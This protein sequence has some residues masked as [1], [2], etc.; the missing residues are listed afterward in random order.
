MVAFSGGADST[1]LLLAAAAVAPGLGLGLHAAW[2]DHGIRPAEERARE[3]TFVEDLASRLGIPCHVEEA[4]VYPLESRAARR[5]TSLE[6]EAREFRYR[7]LRKAAGRSGCERIL[8]AHTRDDQ[9]ETL[10]ARILSGSGAAGLRGIPE[11][12]PPYLRPFLSLSKASL[13]RYLRDRGQEWREDSTNAGEDYLRNRIRLRL[14]PAVEREFPG[15]RKALSKLA[16]KSGFDEDCL[17]ARTEAEL[18][19]SRKE[20]RSSLDARTF[21][22]APPALRIRA[23]TAEA[24]RY[25]E[26]GRRVPYALVRAAA[27]PGVRPA[28]GG[29]LSRGMGIRIRQEGDRIVVSA[30][31]A[32]RLPGL[33]D[34]AGEG[35]PGPVTFPAGYSFHFERPGT[36]RIDTDASCTIYFRRGSTGPGEGTFEFPLT[37][38]SRLPGDRL[39]IP[40]GRKPLDEV[41]ADLKVPREWRDFLPV[42]EDRNGIMGV[43]GFPAGVRDRYR[44]GPGV[45][46]PNGLRLAVEIEG[47]GPFRSIE[48]SAIAP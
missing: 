14:I 2:V 13:I 46:D 22:A 11:D 39:A 4:P 42:L 21:W 12:R 24:A 48:R 6:A 27:V 33:G 30:E 25:A 17:S 36:L 9:A 35:D 8:T 15:F 1:A 44:A 23:L 34:P 16:E 29:I 20:G 47:I 26:A 19:V 28:C 5:G 32:G 10:L 7:A 37:I 31:A 45:P 3:R 18:P 43:L 40:G 38:R 41:L